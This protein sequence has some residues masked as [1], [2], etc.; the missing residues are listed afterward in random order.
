[1]TITAGAIRRREESQGGR[2]RDAC[3]NV[4]ETERLISGLGGAVLLKHGLSRGK[5]G[6]LAL[7]ALGGALLYRAATGHCHLYEALGVDSSDSKDWL[8]AGGDVHRGVKVER[9]ITINRSPEECYRYWRDLG[10]L[11]R[12]TGHLLSVQVIDERRSHWV[13]KAPAPWAQVEWD[14]EIINDTPNA[15]ISWRSLKD[16]DVDNAGSVR[17]RAAPGGRGTEVTVELNYEPPAGRLGMTLA[18]FLGEEP[19]QQVEDDLRKF[20]Q[21]METGE[22]ATVEGQPSCREPGP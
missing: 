10:N 18:R 22:V 1:M 4:G 6:G 12:F 7:A 3:V 19:G 8:A 16:A 20:K 11:P 15:L 17:F 9:T 21:I 14:A 13:A 2:A 5:L